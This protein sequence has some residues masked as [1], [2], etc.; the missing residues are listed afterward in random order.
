MPEPGSHGYDIKRTRLRGE[1]DNAGIPDEHADA[2]ANDI[3]QGGDEPGPSPSMETARAG[4]PLGGDTG[5]GDPGNVM[6]LRSA[7]FSDGAQIPPQ[8]SKEGGNE[9]PE[10]EW[11]DVPEGTSELVLLCVD[12]DAPSGTF[13]HWLVTGIDPGH[14]A[15]SGSSPGQ[16]HPNGYGEQGYGGPRPPAGDGPH[17]YVFRLYALP[18]GSAGLPDDEGV[19]ADRL[20]SWL[21]D[22]ATATGTLIGLYER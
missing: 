11:D 17:R 18:D 4:G 15:L 13:L 20:R 1:L 3:L 2:A 14:H 19:D 10:L 6:L 16:A 12:P 22:R 9:P 8:H 21:D 7:S 5:S